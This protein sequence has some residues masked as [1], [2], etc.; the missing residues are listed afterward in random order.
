MPEEKQKIL[1]LGGGFGG[2]KAA[3]ELANHPHL[4]TTLISDRPRFRFYPTLYHIATGGS[5]KA[6]SIDLGEI[7]EG[8][9]VDIVVDS[10]KK[11]D[12]K[13]KSVQTASGKKYSYDYLV[14]ALGVVTNY[15]GINGLEK[16]SFGI[17]TNEE[18]QELR[19]HLH[20]LIFNDQKPDLN[21]VVIGGG[22]TGVEL[23]GA[24][25]GYLNHIMKSHG[26]GP[27]RVNIELVE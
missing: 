10:A 19:A 27:K 9:N 21:Y 12:R 7:F 14:I 22:P 3:L 4:E 2:I 25:P 11:L 20:K 13:N 23:A 26:I 24:L 17:K 16:F 6:S 15:F 18:A 1:I 8:K 5:T